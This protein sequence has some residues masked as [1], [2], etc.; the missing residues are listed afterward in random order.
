MRLARLKSLLLLTFFFVF[1]VNIEAWSQEVDPEEA[2]DIYINR[3]KVL[4]VNEQNI[5]KYRRMLQKFV[6]EK[7]VSKSR[8]RRIELVRLIR[9]AHEKLNKEIQDYN[10]VRNE[11]R[12]LYP[13]KDKLAVRRYLPIRKQTIEQIEK[14]M[15]LDAQL[16]AIG[17]QVQRKYASIHKGE[18]SDFV[19][20]YNMKKKDLEEEDEN[21]NR[22]FDKSGKVRRLTLEVK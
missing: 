18:K 13:A 11:V 9:A 5:K 3:I 15:G 12:Y 6:A 16:T 7:Q 10:R 4:H 22:L 14:E 20:I 2:Q 21:S 1:L 8:K 19:K 17:H